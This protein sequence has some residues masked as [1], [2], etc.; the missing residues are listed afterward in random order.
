MET[1][2][3]F[4]LIVVVLLIASYALREQVPLLAWLASRLLALLGILGAV[5]LLAGLALGWD[6]GGPLLWGLGG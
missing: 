2:Y 1:D 5:V 3:R 6:T 4:G